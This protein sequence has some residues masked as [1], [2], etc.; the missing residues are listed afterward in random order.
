MQNNLGNS[1][2]ISHNLNTLY[3]TFMK[4]LRHTRKN[5]KYANTGLVMAALRNGSIGKLNYVKIS[6]FQLHTLTH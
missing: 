6:E 2:N 3:C 1:I 5:S 4:L